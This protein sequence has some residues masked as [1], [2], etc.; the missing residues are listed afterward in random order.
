L[1][2]PVPLTLN[3]ELTLP[4]NKVFPAELDLIEQHLG[5]L[6]REMLWERNEGKD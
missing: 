3:D 6:L 2:E 5:E 1:I 4:E